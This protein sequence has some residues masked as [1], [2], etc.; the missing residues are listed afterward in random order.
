MVG[1]GKAHSHSDKESDQ[2]GDSGRTDRAERTG[3][4][5]RLK[6]G[7]LKPPLIDDEALARRYVENGDPDTF[8]TLVRAHLPTLRRLVAAAG[9]GD[10]H[11]RDDILQEVLI[12]LHRSLETYRFDAPLTTWMYRVARNA[13]L[14]E[15]RRRKRSRM[16]E[17]RAYRPQA[18]SRNPEEAALDAVRIEELRRLFFQL[19]E[20]DRQLLVLKEREGLKTDQI[21]DVLGIPPGTVKSRLARARNRA[22]KL[23][24]KAEK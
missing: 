8:E 22:R 9:I 6:F 23:Y 3:F 20:K 10:A 4:R 15:F 16:R 24:E 11:D 1:A 14:D 17:L 19:K 21:A 13:A 12:R 5:Q 2:T 18:E 7:K